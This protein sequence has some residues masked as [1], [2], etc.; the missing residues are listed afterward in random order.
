MNSLQK[1]IEACIFTAVVVMES[2]WAT[3]A[4]RE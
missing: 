4:A 1:Q 3:I 2:S